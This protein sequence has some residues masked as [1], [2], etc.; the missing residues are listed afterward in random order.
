M[1]ANVTQE[2]KALAKA[3][4]ATIVE[5]DPL[6]GSDGAIRRGGISNAPAVSL[7]GRDFRFRPET[8]EFETLAGR[9]QFGHSRD[10]WG[11]RFLSWNTIPLRHEVIPDAYLARNPA[12]ASSRES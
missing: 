8:G 6:E 11:N 3:Y 4:G 5:S 10:D 7:R 1:P 12:T 9:C 2:R